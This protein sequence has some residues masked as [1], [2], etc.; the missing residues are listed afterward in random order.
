MDP[1]SVIASSIAVMQGVDRLV[2]LLCKARRL[3]EAPAEVDHLLT[4][5][6]QTKSTLCSLQNI[7]FALEERAA[8]S[9]LGAIHFLLHEYSVLIQELEGLTEKHLVAAAPPDWVPSS[10]LREQG[11]PK[12]VASR[13][14][15]ATKKSHVEALREKLGCVRQL[16]LVEM[17]VLSS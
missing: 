7:A 4:E 16:V 1:L 11:R 10:N 9:D 15:W 2:S 13:W 8:S 14:G 6:S 12:S 17:T 5:V 3:K